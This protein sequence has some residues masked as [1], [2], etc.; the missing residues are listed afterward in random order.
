MESISVRAGRRGW[1]REGWLRERPVTFRRVAASALIVGVA[2]SAAVALEG[3]A[4][5]SGLRG[6]LKNEVPTGLTPD[7]F[8]DLTGNWSAWGKGV[9]ELVTKLYTD[10]KL[11]AAAQRGLLKQLQKKIH[12]IDKAIADPRFA[13]LYDPLASLRGRLARRVDVDLAIL[14]TLELKPEEVKAERIK[15]AR[16][17]CIGPAFG[18]GSGP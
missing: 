15:T 9:S 8:S 2:V 13:S 6:I 10:E 12:T 7:S 16:G 14:N 5:R 1:L 3:P 18:P 11:D 4:D 17:Q